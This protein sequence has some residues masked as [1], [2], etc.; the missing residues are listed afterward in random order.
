MDLEKTT[1]MLQVSEKINHIMLYWVPLHKHPYCQ[2]LNDYMMKV[3]TKDPKDIDNTQ[4]NDD[5]IPWCV[6]HQTEINNPD[7]VTE[8]ESDIPIK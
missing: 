2:L 4:H 7:L 3:F 8:L 6:R 5:C 1:H